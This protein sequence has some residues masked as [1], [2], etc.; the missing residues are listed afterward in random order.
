VLEKLQQALDDLSNPDAG[1]VTRRDAA[2]MLG[3]V[4]ARALMVLAQHHDEPDVDVQRSV[5]K[6]LAQAEAALRGVEIETSHDR[7]LSVEEFAKACARAGVRTVSPHEQG[8][9]VESVLKSGRRQTVYVEPYKRRD[10]LDLIRVYSYCGPAD[11]AHAMW[12][13]KAN[14]KLVQ[15]AIAIVHVG[16]EE[17]IAVM[18]CFIASEATPREVKSAVKEI[19]FYADWLESKLTGHDDF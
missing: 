2:E 13:L 12:S 3:Q 11:P 17:R 1:W 8:F 7:G 6:G 16:E 5:E 15:A 10:G 14:A 19:A 18:N 9:K 4:A